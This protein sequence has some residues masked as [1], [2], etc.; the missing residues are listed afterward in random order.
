MKR[1]TILE[2]TLWKLWRPVLAIPLLLS[3]A[4]CV[5][6]LVL[7]QLK[8]EKRLWSLCWSREAVRKGISRR[9]ICQK[10]EAKLL[11]RPRNNKAWR[12]RHQ[13]KK[14]WKPRQHCTEKLAACQ[15]P[16]QT[17]ERNTGENASAGGESKAW[18]LCR[19]WRLLK[20]ALELR[21]HLRFSA[22]LMAAL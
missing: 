6:Y 1:A 9:R 3:E 14:A 13:P 12:Q 17:A 18:R 8:S 11:K 2:K 7:L 16:R 10:R 19:A 5:T 4:A 22:A 21:K 15:L 20:L